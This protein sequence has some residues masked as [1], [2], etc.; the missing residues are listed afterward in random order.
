[1][2]P[3]TPRGRGRTPGPARTPGTMPGKSCSKPHVAKTSSETGLEAAH[4]RA[5]HLAKQLELPQQIEAIRLAPHCSCHRD[6]CKSYHARAQEVEQRLKEWLPEVT[7]IKHHI[8]SHATREGLCSGESRGRRRLCQ[9]PLPR[10]S[11]WWR[12]SWACHMVRSIHTTQSS[13]SALNCSIGLLLQ[14]HG[15]C[16]RQ[17]LPKDTAR[18]AAAFPSC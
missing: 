6:S 15:P 5:P 8:H 16:L 9:A 7:I 10:C 14:L 4:L 12:G 13:L 18:T 17:I 2:Q 11:G 3:A 1:M